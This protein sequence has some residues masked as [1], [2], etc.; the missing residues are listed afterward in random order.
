MKKLVAVLMCLITLLSLVSCDEIN[1]E[2]DTQLSDDTEN[3]TV[4]ETMKDTT[5]PSNKEDSVIDTVQNEQ[6]RQAY[7]L[8]LR[9]EIYVY[10]PLLYSATPHKTYFEG[11]CGTEKG[12]PTR[13]A[14]IDMD[15]DGIEEL[16]LAYDSFFI[17][18]TSFFAFVFSLLREDWAYSNPRGQDRRPSISPSE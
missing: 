12:D 18:L 2:A 7:G 9:N 15:K 4:Q 5:V 8:A 13:Q 11:I 1:N 6:A 17:I 10:Y 14:L 16:I 3:T